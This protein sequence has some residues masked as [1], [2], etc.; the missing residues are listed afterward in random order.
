MKKAMRHSD[1]KYHMSGSKFDMLTGSRAQVWHGTAYKTA[2]DLKKGDLMM[3][4]HGRI[5]SRKKHATAKKERRLEKAGY[6]TVKGKF[7]FVKDGA[8]KKRK[9]A[10]KG[11]KGSRKR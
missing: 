2:G 9:T 3:N 5:V 1:G 8:P 6:K 4:K 11:R 7:G 10:R